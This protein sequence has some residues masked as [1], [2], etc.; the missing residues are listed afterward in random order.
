MSGTVCFDEVTQ[1]NKT[2]SLLA[3]YQIC[4]PKIHM[5]KSNPWC[6]GIRRR[7]LW[8]VIRSGKFSPHEWD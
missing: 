7:G 5:L 6:G 2:K 8:E 1:M 4:P 3:M